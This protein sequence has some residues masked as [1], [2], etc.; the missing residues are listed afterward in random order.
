MGENF[1]PALM[2]LGGA[3]MSL[4]YQLLS[5]LNGYCPVVMGF[6][7]SGSYKTTALKSALAILGVHKN[8]FFSKCTR[9]HILAECTKHNCPLGID[10]PTS[11]ALVEQLTI[12]LYNQAASGT[13][14]HGSKTPR[15]TILLAANFSIG[16]NERYAYIC[17]Q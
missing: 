14:R 13:L 10:D 3:T 4:H 5:D 2:F 1:P 16:G 11:Q 12:D 9:E 17:A 15:S 7:P 8:R 6:G